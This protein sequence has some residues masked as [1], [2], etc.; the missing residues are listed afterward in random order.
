MK[1]KSG[2]FGLIGCTLLMF[3]AGAAGPLT[4]RD[5]AIISQRDIFHPVVAKNGMVATQEHHATLAGLEVL[6][7]GGNAVDAAVTV[8]FT[9]AVTLPRA[10]SWR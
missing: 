1:K 2:W 4:A 8:A 9:L 10:S 3:F 7:E 6:K 5:V